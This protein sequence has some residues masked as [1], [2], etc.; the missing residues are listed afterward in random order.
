MRY[1]NRIP[2][3][4]Y[5]QCLWTVKDIERLRRLEAIGEYSQKNNEIVYFVDEDE[6][7]C[8]PEVIEQAKWKLECIRKALGKIPEEYRK[9]T[10]ESIELNMPYGDMAHENTWRKWRQIFM[11]ELAKNLY[12]I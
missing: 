7:I 2:R 12:L 11:C 3:N 4:I 6:I 10:I 9:A 5:Y 1:Q 8:N